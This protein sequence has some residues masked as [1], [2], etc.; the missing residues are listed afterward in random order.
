MTAALQARGLSEH[1][2][3]YADFLIGAIAG[4][5]ALERLGATDMDLG[6]V[7]DLLRADLRQLPH[8][9]ALLARIESFET[10]EKDDAD[11]LI[12]EELACASCGL[13]GASMDAFFAGSE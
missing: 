10:S 3:G 7:V 11:L 13:E 8:S 5:C 2:A 6:A 4:A 12:G 1:W 9:D